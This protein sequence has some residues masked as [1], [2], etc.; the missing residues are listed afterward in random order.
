MQPW[1]LTSGLK[2]VGILALSHAAFRHATLNDT[3]NSKAGT[4]AEVG[5]KKIAKRPALF[6]ASLYGLGQFLQDRTKGS[7]LF[8]GVGAL[9]ADVVGALADVREGGAVTDSIPFKAIAEGKASIVDAV[10]E[11]NPIAAIT[12]LLV[13]VRYAFPETYQDIKNLFHR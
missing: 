13:S 11:M 12:G 8:W 7:F 1:W 10:K 5:F 3:L 6:G 2:F 4:D 9:V